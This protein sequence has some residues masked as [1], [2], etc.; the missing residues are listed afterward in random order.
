MRV[1]VDTNVIIS[2]LLQTSPS[3]PPTRILRAALE[4][5]FELILGEKQIDEVVRSVR[6]KL[7]LASRISVEAAEELVATLRVVATIVPEIRETIPALTRDPG[8][9]YLIAH[10]IRDEVDVVVCGDKD[11][12]AFDKPDSLRI[13]SP[14]DFVRILDAQ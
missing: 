8:D 4:G 11:L 12:L 2:Y 14:A 6:S 5:R 13:V 3:S 10:A 1:I 9:D 7:G